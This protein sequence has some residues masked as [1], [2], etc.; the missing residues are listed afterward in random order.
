MR[1]TKE[2]CEE[3][4]LERAALLK[5]VADSLQT[6]HFSYANKSPRQ[7]A[8]QMVLA[9]ADPFDTSALDA[10]VAEAVKKARLEEMQY[11]VSRDGYPPLNRADRKH[12]ETVLS[13]ALRNNP[14]N[15]EAVTVPEP[16][17][18]DTKPGE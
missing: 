9:M 1:L 16:P 18:G 5:K 7:E 11:W 14:Q 15:S 6:I 12:Y 17:A 2:I 10:V 8:I 3:I 4:R 13:E